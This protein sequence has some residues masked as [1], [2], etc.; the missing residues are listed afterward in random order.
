MR[1]DSRLIARSPQ[2]FHGSDR[3]MR[4]W[5]VREAAELYGIPYWGGD[6]FSVSAEGDMLVHPNGPGTST[7]NLRAVVEEL[8]GR[9]LRTPLVIRFSDILN[10]RVKHISEAFARAIRDYEYKGRYR[11]VYPIKV[12]QQR[13]VVEELVN[14]GR[15]YHLGLEVGSKP[16]LLVGLALLNTPEALIICNGYKDRAYMEL[17]LLA[18]R[19]GR[20]VVIVIDRPNEL[21][22]LI[23]ASRE[24]GIRPHI[25]VR[26]RL[27]ARGAG[28]W[29][30]SSGDRSK[31]GLSAEE[32]VSVVNRLRADDML[33]CL[34]MLHFHNGSQITAIRSHKDAFREASHIYTE[35]HALGAPMRLMDVGG[36]LGIDYD[37]S[38][39]NFH[40]S[41]N[42]TTQEYAY[43]VVAAVRDI[44]D[45]KG[46]PH[47]DIVTEAG[48]ALVS[49][50]S[51]LIFDVL[52]VDGVRPT[53]QPQPPGVDDPKVI[54]QLHEVL[55]SI[56]ARNVLESYNDALQ[57]KE[58]ATTAF[59]LGYLDLQTRARMEELFWACTEKIMRIVR[60]MEYVPEDLQRLDRQLADTY[61]GNFSVFQSLP[62]SWAMKQLFPVVPIHRLDE[63]P[64]RRGTFADLTCDS[65]GKVAQFIDLRDVKSVL[66]LH[67]PNGRPYYIGVFLVGAYQETLGEM[68]NLFGDTDAVHV[69][70]YEDGGYT[71]EQVVEGDSVEEVIQYLGYDRRQLS[72]QVRLAAETAMREGRLTI[73]ESALL[74]RRFEQGI[75]GYTYLEQES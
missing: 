27:A 1:A 7:V 63:S 69:K 3:S 70:I 43:D 68:H 34:E 60:D 48:R 59:S 62:D 75:S 5:T 49:H 41:M 53:T 32:L 19:L 52:G 46:V 29:A 35:L 14:Y 40:S 64:S 13:Q 9:G 44:C 51:V 39:T 2:L 24:L 50:A 28:K 16:E 21:E 11:G 55:S 71:V 58:E 36:G 22:T 37:G 6:Y 15:P 67:A 20:Y 61:Y 8:R 12:N 38:Q 56:S 66:E 73:E 23:K 65:D 45:E 72:E 31:F 57:L 33:D 42:Y 10:S 18:Q 47:P 30:E 54:Q 74:R 25:G 17:A 4:A 26:A